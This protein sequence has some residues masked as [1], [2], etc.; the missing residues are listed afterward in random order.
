MQETEMKCANERSLR[1][2]VEKWLAP[3]SMPVHVRQFS[4][5][6]SDRRRYVCVEA[7]H[8]AASRALFFFRHDDGHWC[9]YPPAP[10]QSNMR[11]ER[12]AA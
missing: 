9:V 1:Y 8:G 2:Q 11:S 12:L 7:L 5:T 6:R 10:K 4:R 3:G